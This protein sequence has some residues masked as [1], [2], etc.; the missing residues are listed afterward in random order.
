MGHIDRRSISLWWDQLPTAELE[1]S[2]PCLPGSCDTDVAIVGAGY[3]GLWT[4]YYLKTID[5]TIRVTVIDS[6]FVGFGASGRNGGWVSAQFPTSLERIASTSG[7]E[8]AIAM[9]DALHDAIDE[10]SRV[11]EAEGIDGFNKGGNVRAARSALALTRAKQ[12]VAAMRSWGY[13]EQDYRLLTLAE[14]RD[15]AN[16][17]GAVGAS[18]TP[19]C[20]VIQP[21]KLVRGLARAA[22]AL[23][24]EIFEQTAATRIEARRVQTDYGTISA[25]HVVLATEAFTSNLPGHHRDSIPVYSLMIA[26]EPLPDDVWS[27][28]GMADRPAFATFQNVIV[29]GHRTADNRIAFGGRGAPYHLGSR[30]KPEYDRNSRV[31]DGLRD[32]LADLVPATVDFQITHEWGGPVGIPRDWFPAVRYDRATGVARSGGYVGDGVSL[33]AL[34]GRTIAELITRQ[35]TV[36]TTLPWVNHPFR[37]WEP[38]PLRWIG[39]NVGVVVAS[40]ADKAEARSGRPA[41]RTAVL[42]KFLGG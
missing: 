20:A 13:G 4:A 2:R 33:A 19:H 17:A 5:P 6:A 39:A 34:G 31:H 23:G 42:N 3:T 25:D 30:I 35:D 10:I 28:I 29:Y 22:E 15:A 18:Y 41:K 36:R 1:L 24:V 16:I 26:T 21:A 14:T 27:K 38:E 9:Q 37:K 12:R 8:S 40:G 11:M 32:M 7:R